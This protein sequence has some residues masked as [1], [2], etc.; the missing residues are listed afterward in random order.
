MRL[1]LPKN[2]AGLLRKHLSWFFGPARE[3]GSGTIQSSRHIGSR[4]PK[5]QS[6][7]RLGISTLATT[8]EMSDNSRMEN[9]RTSLDFTGA[10]F[11]EKRVFGLL[12]VLGS[13]RSF[14]RQDR[15][16][17]KKMLGEAVS[18]YIES[19]MENNSPYLRP[20]PP[21]EDP[22]LHPAENVVAIFPLRIRIQVHAVV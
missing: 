21:E 17:A 20:V 9:T 2:Q 16:R 11:K 4:V 6:C 12:A 18:L 14:T 8:S 1:S 22:R 3:I 7:P 15:A 10:L 5:S 19:C 13:R